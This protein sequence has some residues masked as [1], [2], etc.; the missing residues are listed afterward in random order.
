MMA[1]RS[2]CA[3]E[4]DEH[5]P[6][7]NAFRPPVVV[8]PPSTVIVQPPPPPSAS[9]ESSTYEKHTL[10]DSYMCSERFRDPLAT[11]YVAPDGSTTTTKKTIQQD[12]RLAS[13]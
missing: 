7:G 6:Q 10:T 12:I 11:S 9:V 1:G 3:F 4:H 5:E 2:L 13:C 8:A